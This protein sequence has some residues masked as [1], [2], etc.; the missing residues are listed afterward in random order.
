[1]AKVF[2]GSIAKHLIIL[3]SKLLTNIA[4]IKLILRSTQTAKQF[5]LSLPA[6]STALVPGSSCPLP[7]W[8]KD[9]IHKAQL[10]ALENFSLPATLERTRHLLAEKIKGFDQII[11][12]VCC[13]IYAKVEAVEVLQTGA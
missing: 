4:Q 1:M 3:T 10:L 11:T 7:S 9:T 6:V 5:V 8:A 13:S 2:S 12:N